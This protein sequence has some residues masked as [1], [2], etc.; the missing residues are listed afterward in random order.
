MMLKL[1]LAL[2]AGVGSCVAQTAHPLVEL[3]G[4]SRLL[5]VFS[6][7]CN[8]ANFKRQLELIERHSFELTERNLVVIPVAF[9]SL[10]TEDH[11]SG[12][13]VL[14]GD[15]QVSTRSRFH[16]Q[17]EEFLVIV[18]NADGTERIRS[19][20]PMNIHELTARLDPPPKRPH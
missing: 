4:T 9:A 3:Q 6:P 20:V 2:L 1:A 13:N 19:N 10:G 17:R 11:F 16:V 5:M 18:L 12:E 15:Y 14:L 8:D 7:D